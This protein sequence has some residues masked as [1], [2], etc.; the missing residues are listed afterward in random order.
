MIYHKTFLIQEVLDMPVITVNCPALDV[1]KKREL[2]KGFTEIASSVMGIPK[3]AF[4][5]LIN[6][7]SHENVGVGGNLLADRSK[8][9]EDAPEEKPKRGGCRRKK[10]EG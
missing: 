7:N 4:V 10:A 1:E 9:C 2:V 8:V 5:V 6:E 3:E